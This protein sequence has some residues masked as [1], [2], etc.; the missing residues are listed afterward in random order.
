MKVNFSDMYNSLTS[1]QKQP[2]RFLQ[3]SY[4]IPPPPPFLPSTSPLQNENPPFLISQS[5]PPLPDSLAPPIPPPFIPLPSPEPLPPVFG[6]G[7]FY[8]DESESYLLERT[9]VNQECLPHQ[10]KLNEPWPSVRPKRAYT[11]GS[12]P[13]FDFSRLCEQLAQSQNQKSQLIQSITQFEDYMNQQSHHER[14][15]DFNQDKCLDNAE[16]K[17]KK[18]KM[19]LEKIKIKIATLESQIPRER[20]FPL[21]YPLPTPSSKEAKNRSL[22]KPTKFFK[23]FKKRS[24]TWPFS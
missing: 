19:L 8:N 17:L 15:L 2:N 9:Y 4:T 21:Y 6:P 24:K 3:P 13:S 14:E 10:Q 5:A 11:E 1:S 23:I 7:P 22:K 20:G 12:H 16:R 18:K